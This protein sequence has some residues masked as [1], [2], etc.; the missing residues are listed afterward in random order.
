MEESISHFFSFL[1]KL[2]IPI[3]YFYTLLCNCYMTKKQYLF[4]KLYNNCV[5]KDK[6]YYNLSQPIPLLFRII[7]FVPV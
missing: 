1:L 5:I 3:L 7:Q 2:T 4:L 6:V